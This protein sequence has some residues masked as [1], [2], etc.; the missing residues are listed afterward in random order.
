M[1]TRGQ[2]GVRPALESAL[3]DHGVLVAQVLE[4]EGR[5]R[6]PGAGRA[7]DDGSA[8]GVEGLIVAGAG[9]FGEELEQAPGGRNRSID[10]A[11]LPLL[12]PRT[13]TTIAV[14][15]MTSSAAACGAMVPTWDLASAIICMTVVDTNAPSFGFLLS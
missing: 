15:A 10:V 3:E 8:G 13:S 14:P 11:V 5:E 9:R 7:H 12:G 6:S 1:L 4:R 2:T